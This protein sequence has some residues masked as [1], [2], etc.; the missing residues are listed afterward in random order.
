MGEWYRLFQ[1]GKRQAAQFCSLGIFQWPRGS[2]RKYRSKQNANMSTS[3][4]FIDHNSRDLIQTTTVAKKSQNKGFNESYNGSAPVI[5][6]CTFPSQPTQNKQVH[7]GGIIFIKCFLHEFSCSQ[8]LS[9]YKW[10]DS[11]VF[12]LS[13]T[14]RRHPCVRCPTRCDRGQK[15]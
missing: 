10:N 2:N 14:R 3:W 6:L 11:K 7:Y 8:Y 9:R 4:L 15:N 12:P 13:N 1:C 5:Y